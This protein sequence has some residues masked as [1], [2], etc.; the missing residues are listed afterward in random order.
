MS[1]IYLKKGA[2]VD[3]AVQTSGPLDANNNP[4]PFASAAEAGV[5]PTIDSFDHLT[6]TDVGEQP[7]DISLTVT[8]IDTESERSTQLNAKWNQR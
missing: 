3:G 1:I 8:G 5:L 7:V 6:L 4:I 2:T